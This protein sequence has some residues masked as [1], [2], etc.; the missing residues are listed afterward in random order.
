MAND[1]VVAL[2]APATIPDPLADL[3]QAEWLPQYASEIAEAR[4][5]LAT[6]SSLARHTNDGA[7]R[8]KTRTVE[9]V[10]AAASG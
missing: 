9:E 3:P 7:V 1:N 5:R 6:E 8:V 4:K 2:A 10:R